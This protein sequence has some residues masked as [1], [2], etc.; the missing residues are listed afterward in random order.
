MTEDRIR[1]GHASAFE[2][3]AGGQVLRFQEGEPTVVRRDG[4]IWK[5]A[6]HYDPIDPRPVPKTAWA[7]LNEWAALA[8]LDRLR[9]DPRVSPRLISA[10]HD[11]GILAMEDLGDAPSLV[12]VLH[13][14]DADAA[15]DACVAHS[16]ALARLHRATIGYDTE[17]HLKRD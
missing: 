4:V 16:R 5:R 14:A 8:H 2:Q 13:A 9:L 15:A 10:D 11:T 12:E 6:R 7:L 3:T 17:F 1:V